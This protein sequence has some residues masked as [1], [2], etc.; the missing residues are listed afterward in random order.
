MSVPYSSRLINL[1]CLALLQA[2]FGT[3][4]DSKQLAHAINYKVSCRL[5]VKLSISEM[6]L[7]SVLCIVK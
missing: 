2:K 6:F 5:S 4:D 1:C 3:F 7:H